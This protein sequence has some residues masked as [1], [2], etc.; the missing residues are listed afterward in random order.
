MFHRKRRGGNAALV[1]ALSLTVLLGVA[2]IA[3]DGGMARHHRAELQNAA[4]AAA[5]AAAL[6]FDGTEDGL[7][8]ARQAAV[9]I[10]ALNF[11][12]GQAVVLDS[13]VSNTATGDIV[14]GEWDGDTRVFTPTVDVE[15]IN[16]FRVRGS[17]EELQTFFANAA[18]GRSSVAV[19]TDS[20]ALRP[21]T[22]PAGAVE[23]FLPLAVPQCRLD[24][25]GAEGILDVD[26]VLNPSGGD[27]V[28]WALLGNTAV[29]DSSLK[30]QIS[31]CE[32]SGE[33]EDS[34]TVSLDGAVITSVLEEIADAVNNSHTYW[35]DS[36]WGV[37]PSPIWK[38]LVDKDGSYGNTFE[39]AIIVFDEEGEDCD[40]VTFS[41]DY[42][43]VSFYKAAIY[44]VRSKGVVSEGNI[45]V[46]IDTVNKISLGTKGGGTADDGIQYQPPPRIVR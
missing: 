31:N 22:T 10:A 4:D 20:I 35:D 30:E 5:H 14:S 40:S 26:L 27:N 9:T 11:A 36:V 43:V 2:A 17:N 41:G 1:T 23:C 32:A 42:S 12:G 16:A 33:V 34:S 8:E 24:L 29:S 3:V 28:G 46:R 6:S 25:Y 45:R 15:L 13:N 39:G 38:S 21:P 19:S 18:F 44:D 37:Q 7:L